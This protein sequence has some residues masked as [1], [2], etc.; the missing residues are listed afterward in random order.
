MSALVR[1]LILEDSESDAEL[2]RSE[3][4]H[5]ALNVQ[6][7]HARSRDEFLAALRKFEPTVVLSDHALADFN[8]EAA[9]Q[10]VRAIRPA[11]P[12]IVVTG[13]VDAK[14]VV[15]CIRAGAED[16]VSKSTLRRLPSAITAALAVR[17]RLDLLSP[18]QLQVL[19]LAAE[20]LTT[21]AIARKLRLS[22]KT[23]ETHRTELMKRLDV[24]DVAALVRYAARVGLI[25]LTDE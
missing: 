25:E 9:L 16:V 8:T 5:S 17:R 19:R 13:L 3:L 15:A 18:R 22:V 1:V 2:I 14:A 12:V 23:V 4:E 11:T 21:S 6:V 10:A 20:G 24:H 7:E